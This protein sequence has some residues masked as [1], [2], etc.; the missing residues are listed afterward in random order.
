MGGIGGPGLGL[1]VS[2]SGF[3]VW[4][5]NLGKL[6]CQFEQRRRGAE[7]ERS[8]CQDRCR[9]DIVNIPHPVRSE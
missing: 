3:R 7:P 8:G 9:L 6:P 1:R 4:G 2:G 5:E